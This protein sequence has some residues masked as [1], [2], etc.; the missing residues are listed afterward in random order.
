MRVEHSSDNCPPGY[1]LIIVNIC[2]HRSYAWLYRHTDYIKE[3]Y[4]EQE[5]ASNL[6]ADKIVKLKIRP[7]A[8]EYS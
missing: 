4:W 2:I 6:P 5:G 3:A 8:R 7:K 1:I